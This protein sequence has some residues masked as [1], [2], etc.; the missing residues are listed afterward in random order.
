MASHR[1]K[2][3]RLEE[4]HS[5]ESDE[6]GK[7][8]ML[9]PIRHLWMHRELDGFY[10]STNLTLA[11]FGWMLQSPH[12]A[13][14]YDPEYAIRNL[15]TVQH[16]EKNR[17]DL[18]KYVEKYLITPWRPLGPLCRDSLMFNQISLCHGILAFSEAASTHAG[19]R[20]I[21]GVAGQRGW[22]VRVVTEEIVVG[23]SEVDLGRADEN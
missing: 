18:E 1:L 4:G 19:S 7:R 15:H 2:L 10:E 3:P 16:M 11:H 22:A 12:E 23:L 9:I 14:N 5:W 20:E 13:L 6:G 21:V 8:G 17:A